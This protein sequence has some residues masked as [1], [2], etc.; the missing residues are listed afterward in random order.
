MTWVIVGHTMMHCINHDPGS[1]NALEL[2]G[3]E[4]QGYA[5]DWSG[6]P[7]QSAFFSVDTFFFMGGLLAVVI[8][9]P[10]IH[11]LDSIAKVPL[12]YVK[13]WLRLT[14]PLIL[15][16]YIYLYITPIL[17]SGPWYGLR[18]R[19]E[20]CSK[21]WWTNPLFIMNIIPGRGEEC[22]GEA[23]YLAVDFQLFMFLPW[24]LLLHE[25]S[26]KMTWG[27]LLTTLVAATTYTYWLAYTYEMH[28]S[29][30][31]VFVDN[32][33]P[34]NYRSNYYFN[35]FTRSPPY[36]VGLLAGFAWYDW[37][38]HITWS[39]TTNILMT[40]TWANLLYWPVYGGYWEYQDFP[41]TLP[42]TTE[43]AYIAYTKTAWAVGLA[44]LC[45]QCFANRGGFFQWCLSFRCYVP[46]AK[47]SYC[48][49]LMHYVPQTQY[50]YSDVTPISGSAMTF[51]V[52]VVAS[53][54]LSYV[55]AIP[56]YILVEYGTKRVDEEF[57]TPKRYAKKPKQV[58]TEGKA[59]GVE[60]KRDMEELKRGD[61]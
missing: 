36:I 19:Q 47:L 39:R 57:L 32:A 14:P 20:F 9:L 11:M 49:F 40:I 61:V 56:L 31:M 48:A 38:R 22:F 5:A 51:T 15:A 16:I 25:K 27:V 2:I 3:H 23:W 37:I 44:I 53:I 30:F 33:K 8:S 24:V 21:Y 7:I 26:I 18:D 46:M 6:Q 45:I 41:S 34:V 4:G 29:A 54:V 55:Y 12:L 13:R 52:G 60:S 50:Y 42:M 59:I 35:T 10:K 43:A 28:F 17:G 58:A 1:A